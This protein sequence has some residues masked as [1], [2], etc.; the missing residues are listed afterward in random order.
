MPNNEE[1]TPNEYDTQYTHVSDYSEYAKPTF[2][3][4][5]QNFLYDF[6][7]SEWFEFFY[8]K[9]VGGAML[10]ATIAYCKYFFKHA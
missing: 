3:E 9:V 1:E 7:R 4:R 10:G 2:R 5:F 6:E 8:L